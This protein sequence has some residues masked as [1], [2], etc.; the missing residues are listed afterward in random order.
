MVTLRQATREDKAELLRL[1]QQLY[2]PDPT[3]GAEIDAYF[4]TTSP[5]ELML[6]AATEN[7][8]LGAFIELSKRDYAEGCKSSPVAYIEGIFVDHNLR[9]TGI[10]QQLMKAAESWARE[11]GFTEMASDTKRGNLE[12]ISFH[13]TAGFEITEQITCFRKQLM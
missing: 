10:G 4:N 9:R 6:V 1:Q 7:E 5:I 3:L 12:S 13:Q 8:C 2:N 11:N